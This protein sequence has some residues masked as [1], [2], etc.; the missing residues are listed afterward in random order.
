MIFAIFGLSEGES[1]A[2]YALIGVIV[3]G[4]LN[5]AVAAWQERRRE[6]R[7][8]RPATRAVVRELS[9]MQAILHAPASQSVPEPSAWPENFTTLASIVECRPRG[10]T[11]H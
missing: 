9:E 10:R 6:R 8:T 5:A 11:Q 7:A 2:V 3:G 1:A 4:M